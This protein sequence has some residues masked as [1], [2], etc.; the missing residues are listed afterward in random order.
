MLRRQQRQNSH[1]ER[2]RG[3]SGNG[4]E[5]ADGQI[6][7]AGKKQA[8]APAHFGGHIKQAL[9]LGK[10]HRNDAQQREAHTG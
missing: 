1:A 10:T 3:G 8:V 4:K 2:E 7:H 6:Q 5:R 9:T